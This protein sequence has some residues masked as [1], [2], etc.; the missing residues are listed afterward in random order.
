MSTNIKQGL[1]KA[2]KVSAGMSVGPHTEYWAI[3][4]DWN[5]DYDFDDAGELEF[6][7]S[8]ASTGVIT[9]TVSAPATA[10]PGLTRMRISMKYGSAPSPCEAFGF[11]EVE[12]YSLNV[13]PAL[14]PG[15]AASEIEFSV[16]PNPVDNELTATW[17]GL[18][19]VELSATIVDLS[20]KAIANYNFPTENGMAVI[21]F[22]QVPAGVYLVKFESSAGEVFTQTIIKD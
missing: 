3:W 12:D 22:T 19:G 17:S 15:L 6:S 10:A 16:Y 13:I 21:P 2:I 8:S 20:G 5:H 1:S 4:V 18:A 11:G 14:P 9:G 7:T